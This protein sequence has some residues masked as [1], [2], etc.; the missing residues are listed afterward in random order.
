LIEISEGHKV[1]C[2]LYEDAEGHTAP[3]KSGK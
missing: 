3:K 2:W 1:R